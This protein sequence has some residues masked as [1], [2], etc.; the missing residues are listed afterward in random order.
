MKK[1]VWVFG[2]ISGIIASACMV[3]TM[4]ICYNSKKFEGSMLLGYSS[5]IVAFSFIFVAVK[6]YRDKYRN[7]VISFGAA[8]KMG[9]F[10]ALIG[11]SIYVISWA[12]LYHFFM[13]DWMQQFSSNSL[14]KLKNS[15]AGIKAMANKAAEMEMYKGYYKNPAMFILFTYFEILP[16]GIIVA[17]ITALILKK[18]AAMAIG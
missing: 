14:Q 6:N 10:I 4:V 2:L 16:V 8:L 13:P 11:S 17:L 12:I 18:K 7:G 15:G 9:F 3:T 5:M 1:N